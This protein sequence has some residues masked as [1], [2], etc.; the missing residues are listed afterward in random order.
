[1]A[2]NP[3]GTASS[4]PRSSAAHLR[5]HA[6]LLWSGLVVGPEPQPRPASRCQVLSQDSPT[7][8]SLTLRPA[9]GPDT[10]VGGGPQA[11]ALG[12]TVRST[13]NTTGTQAWTLAHSGQGGG[14]PRAAPRTPTRPRAWPAPASISGQLPTAPTGGR[15]QGGASRTCALALEDPRLSPPSGTR[16]THNTAALLAHQSARILRWTPHGHIECTLTTRLSYLGAGTLEARSARAHAHAH[17]HTHA[18]TRSDT[19]TLRHTH[20]HTHATNK[21]KNTLLLTG[22]H[23]HANS[24]EHRHA[25][26]RSQGHRPSA[27]KNGRFFY[28]SWMS[29]SSKPQ[30]VAHTPHSKRLQSW[31]IDAPFYPRPWAPGRN[32]AAPFMHSKPSP[33][34]SVAHGTRPTSTPGEH[35]GFLPYKQERLLLPRL[36]PERPT[37]SLV[38]GQGADAHSD[39]P[40]A[41]NGPTCKPPTNPG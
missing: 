36:W 41:G 21:R 37:T 7:E 32:G 26:T 12:S 5:G 13:P 20:T 34:S 16:P 9:E 1:M 22:T 19:H 10:E 39:R 3:S 14:R 27:N 28:H 24:C 17:T 30:E 18:R 2:I 33:C 8:A 23:A 40:V 4:P 29:P 31:T 15:G 25:R 6:G 38:P 35:L 11:A